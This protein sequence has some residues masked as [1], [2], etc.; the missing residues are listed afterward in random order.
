MREP[1]TYE[2]ALY[3]EGLVRLTQ[4]RFQEIFTV[5]RGLVGDKP[6]V[7]DWQEEDLA[8]L[9]RAGTISGRLSE[10][11]SDAESPSPRLDRFHQDALD[12]VRRYAQALDAC[13]RAASSREPEAV[14]EANRLVMDAHMQSARLA[15]TLA[16]AFEVDL[17]SG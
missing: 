11:W 2:E 16:D 15:V 8:L 5:F 7:R 14:A 10:A 9:D 17:P 13:Y 1:M 3:I 12:V 6:D 4:E